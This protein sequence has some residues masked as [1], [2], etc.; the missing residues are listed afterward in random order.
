MRLFEGPAY[1]ELPEEPLGRAWPE[2]ESHSD[3]RSLI[4]V[5]HTARGTLL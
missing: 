3:Y 4:F 1:L 5:T 2:M